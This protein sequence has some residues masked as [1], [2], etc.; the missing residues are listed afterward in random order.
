MH[1]SRSVVLGPYPPG[2]VVAEVSVAQGPSVA[3][4][5][6]SGR[7]FAALA[8]RDADGELCLVPLSAE[9]TSALGWVLVGF[10]REIAR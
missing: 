4:Y 2:T 1:S 5:P 7:P 10:G 9:L 3:G 6:W 8:L